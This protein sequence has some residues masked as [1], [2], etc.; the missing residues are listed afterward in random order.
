MLQCL[1]DLQPASS[2]GWIAPQ[3]SLPN[4]VANSNTLTETKLRLKVDATPMGAVARKQLSNRGTLAIAELWPI[5]A[6]HWHQRGIYTFSLSKYLVV[7][8]FWGRAVRASLIR[9][10]QG[11]FLFALQFAVLNRRYDPL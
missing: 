9:K 4:H 7:E 1:A 8:Q 5:G 3:D 10:S 11:R 2:C 6:I